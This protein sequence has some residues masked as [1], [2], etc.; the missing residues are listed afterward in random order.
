ML[1]LF[2]YLILSIIGC[3]PLIGQYN[4]T[5]S[6]GYYKWHIESVLLLDKS[7][8]PQWVIT[9]KDYNKGN[10]PLFNNVRE[11]IRNNDN[12]IWI[13]CE[14]YGLPINEAERHTLWVNSRSLGILIGE[15]G[16]DAEEKYGKNITNE[17]LENIEKR[18]YFREIKY[19]NPS[20][21]KRPYGSKF[22]FYVSNL[23]Q[24]SDWMRQMTK[25]DSIYRKENNIK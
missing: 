5:I 4:K 1:K 23:R 22:K 18:I 15:L 2:L 9:T 13:D 8:E 17:E 19:I 21:E 7:T 14:I 12:I 6:V 16:V 10:K 11:Y 20:V 3:F 25:I 24:S